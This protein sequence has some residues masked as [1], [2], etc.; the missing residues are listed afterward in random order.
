MRV[1][2]PAT[3]RVL[4]EADEARG[5]AGRSVGLLGATG[6]LPGR[7]LL[8]RTSQVHTIG[9]LFVIDV[10]Y[11][12]KDGRIVK[13]R[14]LKPGRLG[15]VVPTARWVLELGEGEAARLGLTSGR[16]VTFG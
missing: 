12:T 4:V 11:I 9:M 5:F 2:D 6:L 15:P 1:L 16:N 10:V 13:V 3:G 8:L 7:G 14:T